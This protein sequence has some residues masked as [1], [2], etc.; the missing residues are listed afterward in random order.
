MRTAMIHQRSSRSPFLATAVLGL[1]TASF[2]AAQ[3]PPPPPP[4]NPMA[5][6]LAPL[7]PMGMQR[8]TKLELVVTGTNL[9]GPTGVW[10][11]FPAKVS[12][13]ADMNNGKDQAKLRVVLEVPADAP[14]G[15]HSIRLA[16]T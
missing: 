16:T 7:A 4:P 1:L 15:Y 11:S 3:Q 2:V 13:P 8:G 5:P 12:I 10:T 6:V 14:I 9:A